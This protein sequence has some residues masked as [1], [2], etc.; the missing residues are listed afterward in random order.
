LAREIE[1]FCRNGKP[2]GLAP[3]LAELRQC[4]AKSS[5]ALKAWRDANL[6]ARASA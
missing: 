4:S 3:M 1:H 2:E 6:G 5:A